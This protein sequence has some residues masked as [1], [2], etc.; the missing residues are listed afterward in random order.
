[1]SCRTGRLRRIQVLLLSGVAAIAITGVAHAD[2]RAAKTKVLDKTFDVGAGLFA[3]TE[4]ELSGEPLAENLGLNLDVLD[5]D[6]ADK[7]DPF[8]FAAGIDSY[9]YSEEAMYAV[10]YQS[11]LG[12]HLVNGPVNAKAGGTFQSLADR[13]IHLAKS[14]G[15]APD[16][17]PQNW[18][19]ISIA[20]DKAVPE[21]GQP[22]DV[23][24]VSTDSKTITTHQG[25]AGTIA[26]VI[27]AYFRDFRTLAWRQDG[28]DMN[29]TPIAAGGQMLKDVMWAQD[30][31]GSMHNTADDSEV[32][33]IPN[34]Q[35]DKDGKLALGDNSADGLN[36]VVL[37]QITWDELLTLRDRF[38]YDGSSIGAK[39][40]P[41]YDPAK[42]PV[43]FPAKVAVTFDHK[44][45]VNALG[46]LKVTDPR[47]TLRSTWMLLWP[48]SE[49]YGFSDQRTD[50]ANKSVFFQ[51]AFDGD[52]FP[53]APAANDGADPG[54]YVAADDPFSLAETL[55]NLEL[56]NLIA[57]HFNK[58]A[59]TVVDDWADG[60]QGD[61]VTTFD[62]AYTI[63]ALDI[64]ERA[65]DAL[66]VGYASA[67]SGKPLATPEGKA[68]L[69]LLKTEAD[70]I[71]AKLVGSD[72]L[73]ADS[74][75]IGQGPSAAKSLGTQFAVIR[76]LSVAFTATGNDA[77][78]MAARSIYDAVQKHML[79]KSGLFDPTP[80]KPFTV[81]PWTNGAVSAGLRELLENLANK[82]GESD[83]AL[84]K[85]ALTDAYTTWF[86]TVGRGMQLAEWLEETGEHIVAGDKTGDINQN[87]IKSITFAGGKYG[88][89]Q[90][91]ASK[92]EV[93]P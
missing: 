11:H 17:L 65:L 91:M 55:S 36:G 76:A 74:Y 81:D 33:D 92:I 7:P 54:K 71:T 88:T 28:I 46:R 26:T 53:S 25:Q 75:T 47:S 64:Y 67:S 41:Q 40:G 79:D 6:Q 31:L 18:Y 10:N 87:G 30:F 78:R 61:T 60:K 89:A 32:D 9:E 93:T 48:L 45:G 90:V 13:F 69:D 59:G 63:S 35:A 2:D 37:T 19:P 56:K 42:H 49:L 16:E 39:I 21:F 38:G 70:F 43:W 20:L 50:N 66:P 34:A 86:H 29:F 15:M 27:P 57:L 14:A 3:Y 44:N 83:P 62:A 52:P 73:V 85:E 23:S 12:P 80:G 22:V 1:M 77:Y 51:A 82:E 72:G 84:T 5:A 8:D 58:A 24:Q 4:Y 68:A